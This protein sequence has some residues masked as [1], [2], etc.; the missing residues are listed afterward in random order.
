MLIFR[1]ATCPIIIKGAQTQPTAQG[2]G[3]TPC[4]IW[5]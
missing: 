4:E 1:P 2:L 5:N 3:L